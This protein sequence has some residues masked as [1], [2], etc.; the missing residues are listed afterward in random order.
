M[1]R[2]PL[3]QYYSIWR[4]RNVW[5]R[6]KA[7]VDGV[8]M[9]D[10]SHSFVTSRK[11]EATLD[12]GGIPGDL[13]FG[14]TKSAGAREPMYARG[15][16][17]FNRRQV[18]VVSMEDCASIA[19]KLGVERILPEWLGANIV[20]KYYFNLTWLPSGSRLVFPSGASLV[21]E[22][23]NLPCRH[24]GEVIQKQYPEKPA[25]ATRFVKAAMGLRGIVCVVERQG[26][27]APGDEVE[28]VVYEPPKVRE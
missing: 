15:T 14:L 11:D 4:V 27:I 13:H 21:C 18:S 6:Y 8:L 9:A 1:R 25:L 23:E 24:P 16:E 22:E 26:K 19:T 5:K 28:V 20:L 17:I 7:L 2:R 10:G 12:Y 3:P